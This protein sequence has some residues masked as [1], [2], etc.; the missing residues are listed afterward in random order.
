MV[1]TLFI[2]GIWDR[3][4]VLGKKVL[5]FFSKNGV[6]SVALFASVQFLQLDTVKKQLE[7]LTI[8]V[9]TTK[10]K[11]TDKEI[12]VLGC[13]AYHDSYSEDI[14]SS[15]D[16]ILYIGDGLFHPKALL[17]SQAA[18][19]SVSNIVI[20]DPVSEMMKTLGKK[21]IEKQW[22]RREANL[23]RYIA[24]KT[25]G[26]LVTIKPGQQYLHLAEKLRDALERQDKK[27]YIFIDN[28]IDISLF[29]NYPFI[30]AWVNT[31]CP[32]IGTD[33]IV[34]VKEALVNIREAFD[35][36]KALEELV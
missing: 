21:D 13:D 25:I 31:A 24:A 4:I 10:A 17:L 22:K 2:D 20:W 15:V 32:R 1:D 26:I 8:S 12:Q 23:K 18:R 9:K 19:K 28:T 27:G 11:R 33:D 34:N 14:I 6:K 35:P 7:S 29:E 16:A 3:E 36:V 30:D 5:D